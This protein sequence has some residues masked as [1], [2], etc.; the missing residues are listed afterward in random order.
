MFGLLV[1][2]AIS[3]VAAGVVSDGVGI[4]CVKALVIGS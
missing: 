3:L 1:L 4:E 2:G